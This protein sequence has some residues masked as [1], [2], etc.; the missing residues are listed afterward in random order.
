ME[1]KHE[2][3]LATLYFLLLSVIDLVV[4]LS[5][6]VPYELGRWH[7]IMVSLAWLIPLMLALRGWSSFLMVPVLNISGCDK[8]L[9]LILQ[10]RIFEIGTV[11]A[12][13]NLCGVLAST[14]IIVWLR[15]RK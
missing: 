2:I 9:S 10:G 3:V 6:P 14:L 8:T 13:T 11:L 12:L 1:Q 5:Q 15:G 7:G 4:S